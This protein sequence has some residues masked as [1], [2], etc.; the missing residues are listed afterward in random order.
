L[1]QYGITSNSIE[2]SQ[3]RVFPM[4]FGGKKHI[5]FSPIQ[6]PQLWYQNYTTTTMSQSGDTFT[7]SKSAYATIL[8][9][10][11]K[12]NVFWGVLTNYS[13]LYPAIYFEVNT[14]QTK[15]WG[16][17]VLGNDYQGNSCYIYKNGPL[18]AENY[19]DDNQ[20]GSSGQ[21][22]MASVTFNNVNFGNEKRKRLNKLTFNLDAI[23]TGS[24]GV[25]NSMNVFII[26]ENLVPTT[27]TNE[28]FR[29]L[30]YTASDKRTRFYLNNFGS[31]RNW[32]FS[33]FTLC[34]DD[35]SISSIE[36]DIEQSTN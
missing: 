12:D 22:Y 25:T 34:K 4:F 23:P 36:L 9:Y 20:N 30:Q 18:L 35:F 32:N 10:S 13:W 2:V 24:T 6:Q 5:A 26:K 8:A 19:Y 27:T 17:S 31:A 3:V 16:Q 28:I 7:G 15:F 14:S 11:I 29:G 1:I 33:V 21:P